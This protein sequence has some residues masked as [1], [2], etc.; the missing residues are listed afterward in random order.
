MNN[1]EGA[2][3]A[4]PR[5]KL[6]ERIVVKFTLKNISGETLTVLSRGTPLGLYGIRYVTVK[7]DG[8]ELDYDGAFAKLAPPGEG[9]YSVIQPGGALSAELDIT[10]VYPI[11]HTGKYTVSAEFNAVFFNA[12]PEEVEEV[13]VPPVSFEVVAGDANDAP[14]KTLGAIARESEKLE[15]RAN[16]PDTAANILLPPITLNAS[17]EERTLIRQAHYVAYRFLC[18]AYSNLSLGAEDENQHF[19]MVFGVHDPA[20]FQLVKKVIGKI[21]DTLTREQITYQM[22][23]PFTEPDYD[24]TFGYTFIG[25]RKIYLCGA[26]KRAPLAASDSKM[27]TFAHELSHAICSVNKKSDEKYGR[28]ECRA[29]ALSDPSHAVDNADS[30]EFFIESQRLFWQDYNEI[31]HSIAKENSGGNPVLCEY[32]NELCGFHKGTAA[33]LYMFTRD[34][35][36]WSLNIPVTGLQINAMPSAVLFNGV[37]HMAFKDI[38]L[39]EIKHTSL[40]NDEFTT[41]VSIPGVSTNLSPGLVVYENSLYM[42]YTDA[43]N[44]LIK[45][46]IFD[47]TNWGAPLTVGTSQSNEAVSAAVFN[48]KLNVVYTDGAGELFYARFFAQP[49]AR[50]V[51]NPV[52]TK[53]DN[54][55]ARSP[56]AAVIDDI[57]Y[58]TFR[59][60]A[61]DETCLALLMHMQTLD[62][63]IWAGNETVYENSVQSSSPLV[64][65]VNPK[66]DNPVA[67][68]KYGS[69]VYSVLQPTGKNVLWFMTQVST[70]A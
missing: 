20:R 38:T 12:P 69:L 40:V 41:P 15:E 56:F 19:Y 61:S 63:E 49:I 39:P 31:T 59:R 24:T 52:K 1:F 23:D 62:I 16:E 9:E 47:G 6:G 54:I 66:S 7:F 3:E 64:N 25:T 48:G 4:R 13:N 14:I 26:W 45:Y 42:F 11:E 68:V 2:L 8:N 55:K 51:V 37:L 67:L 60:A 57:M 43:A 22:T 30:Y 65:S 36:E 35:S 32:G 33:N 29:L 5:Y 70:A 27:G 17:D 50:W 34:A 21:R 46:T 10:N 53:T 18:Y 28:R 44:R 58:I